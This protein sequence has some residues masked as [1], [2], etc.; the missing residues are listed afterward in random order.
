MRER[1]GPGEPGP[2]RQMAAVT[3]AWLPGAATA[4]AATAGAATAGA[5][6][7]VTAR[8][9]TGGGP[10][11]LINLGT[12]HPS[13]HGMLRLWL[14]LDSDRISAA[15]PE[16]GFMHRGAEKLFEAR[17]YRQIIVLANRHDWLGAF[18]SE[19]GV[20]L[21]AERLAGIEVPPRAVWART[22]LA[23]LNRALSHLAFLSSYPPEIAA[24]AG[25]PGEPAAARAAFGAR[26]AI[27]SIMEEISGGRMH[28]MFNRV[29]GLKEEI[30]AGWLARACRVIDEVR[31][32]LPAIGATLGQDGFRDRTRG[33]GVLT[34]AQV[35][36][37]GISGPA[38]RAC[39]VDFDLR[40]DE[41]YLAYAELAGVLRVPVRPEGDCLARFECLR[42]QLAVCLDLAQE[43]AGRLAS[44][45]Q[46]PLSARLPKVFKVPEGHAYA[47][48]EGPL[49]LSGYYLVSRGGKTPWRLKLRSASFSNMAVL[50]D[51]LPGHRVADLAA[52]L[53]SLFF[54]VGDMDR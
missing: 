47:W 51:L 31:A 2:G 40:R 36:Q 44:L 7:A 37:Y 16:I 14:T 50:P 4:G 41:P 21:A 22:M 23:E 43:C 29:G 45:P 25:E 42:D 53:G 49:G 46:G 11:F 34:P 5:S 32:A 54:V 6:P 27:Q 9:G 20:V 12:S 10:E 24:A 38:A 26:E 33:I 15:E 48:T 19:L 35:R 18:A 13:A 8:A 28:Y 3:G 30:P 17:D 1:Q 39:G 52:V